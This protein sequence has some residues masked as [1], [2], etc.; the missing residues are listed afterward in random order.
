MNWPYKA[1]L[2]R[3]MSL[4][5]FNDFFVQYSSVEHDSKPIEDIITSYKAYRLS[6]G[7]PIS[8]EENRFIDVIKD[9][10]LEISYRENK[11]LLFFVAKSLDNDGDEVIKFR[12]IWN[13]AKTG[14]FS[15]KLRDR[16]SYKTIQQ[17]FLL[18]EYKDN[19]ITCWMN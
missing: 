7:M 8:E 10:L 12:E 6:N 5:G 11:N 2:Q 17:F 3:L 13:N 16:Q 19:D 18:N 14:R 4:E 15:A 1:L 9:R